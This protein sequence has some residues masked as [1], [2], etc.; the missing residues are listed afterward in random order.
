MAGT[1]TSR[2]L[3]IQLCEFAGLLV[4]GISGD[5]SAWFSAEFIDLIRGVEIFARGMNIQVCWIGS[6]RHQ[7][8][9][10]Q[11]S[12]THLEAKSV[13]ALALLASV[14]SD[15]DEVFPGR[16]RAKRTNRE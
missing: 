16:S 2:R 15:V 6:F 1:R 11:F 8:D 4:H 10:L 5:G 12:R 3:L 7:T 13:D 9:R 14:G